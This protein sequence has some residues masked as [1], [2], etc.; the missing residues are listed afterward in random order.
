MTFQF[1]LV[2][3]SSCCWSGARRP[4]IYLAHGTGCHMGDA[5]EHCHH[6]HQEPAV[7]GDEGFWGS[8]L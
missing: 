1:F 2:S 4:C 7:F 8:G 3:Y 5:C 6:P